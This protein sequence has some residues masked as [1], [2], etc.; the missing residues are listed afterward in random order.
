MGGPRAS[1]GC[2][3]FGG[4]AARRLALSAYKEIRGNRVPLP[5]PVDV[6]E[7]FRGL[8]GGRSEHAPRHS[9][10]QLGMQLP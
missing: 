5:E 6:P 7:F 4:F 9:K 2:P 8:R 1:M 3:N 10:I